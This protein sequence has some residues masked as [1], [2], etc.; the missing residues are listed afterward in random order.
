MA[1]L[2]HFF[3]VCEP[4]GAAPLEHSRRRSLPT[5]RIVVWG[6]L[7]GTHRPLLFLRDSNAVLAAVFSWSYQLQLLLSSQSF[8]PK[9]KSSFI[10]LLWPVA[11]LRRICCLWWLEKAPV[12][13]T[14]QTDV[15]PTCERQNSNDEVGRCTPWPNRLRS[16]KAKEK[17]TLSEHRPGSVSSSQIFHSG[18]IVL[19]RGSF[20]KTK[21]RRYPILLF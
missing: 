11:S 21:L 16:T 10:L 15:Q 13:F 17:K 7:H 6:A 3:H 1:I 9:P 2:A 14:G 19:V 4:S 8:Y 12:R 5:C 20:G 18:V